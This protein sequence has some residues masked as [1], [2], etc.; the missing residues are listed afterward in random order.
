M[1]ATSPAFDASQPRA[2]RPPRSTISA[3]RPGVGDALTQP[4][5]RPRA[6]GDRGAALEHELDLV[7]VEP[8]AVGEQEV[9]AEHA[10]VLEV[11][12]GAATGARQVALGI[13]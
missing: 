12:D 6:V 10:E 1:S 13:R 4:Q 2:T 11:D 8:H 7:V 3:W 5:V 9:R